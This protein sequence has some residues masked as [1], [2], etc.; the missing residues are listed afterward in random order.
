MLTFGR[1]SKFLI[2]TK[3]GTLQTVFPNWIKVSVHHKIILDKRIYQLTERVQ[4]HYSS[5]HR[6]VFF[7]VAAVFRHRSC[8]DQHHLLEQYKV[9]NVLY[10]ST[11]GCFESVVFCYREF[12]LMCSS[13]VFVSGHAGMSTENSR[14]KQLEYSTID[15][16]CVSNRNLF[17]YKYQPS[18][19]HELIIHRFSQV[20]VYFHF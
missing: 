6:G 16:R 3:S 9:G 4:R 20:K 1:E 8:I 15:V 19:I 17:I 13:T 2:T 5:M 7:S 11:G 12:N 14:V 18:F 10:M